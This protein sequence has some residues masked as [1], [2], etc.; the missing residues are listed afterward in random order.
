[1]KRTLALVI[2]ATAA[3]AQD[4]PLSAIDWLSEP[5]P[6]TIVSRL[7]PLPQVSA[8][9][10]P[11]GVRAP[12]AGEPAVSGPINVPQVTSS[13][14]M[15]DGLGTFGLLE[16]APGEVDLWR[17]ADT[18]A[19]MRD[20][21]ALPLAPLP[22]VEKMLER[23]LLLSVNGPSGRDFTWARLKR[24]R[25][26]GH[27][28]QIVAMLESSYPM[29]PETTGIYLDAAL[30]TGREAHACMV[31]DRA[32]QMRTLSWPAQ[33]YCRAVTGDW[34][35]AVTLLTA[36]DG[37][38]AMDADHADLLGYFLDPDLFEHEATPNVPM[39]PLAYRIYDS[40]GQYRTA[41]GPDYDN[42]R[43]S[44]HYGWKTRAEAA[45]RLARMGAIDPADL[46]DIMHAGRPSASGS[47]WERVTAV[48]DVERA[49]GDDEALVEAL[50]NFNQVFGNDPLI[51]SYAAQW[52][53]QLPDIPEAW[54]LRLLAGK[55]M[56]GDRLV[57]RISRDELIE[58]KTLTPYENAVAT[59]FFVEPDALPKPTGSLGAYLLHAARLIEEG[60]TGSPSALRDG[61][62]MLRAADPE[63]ARQVA[64][65]YLLLDQR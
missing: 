5:V 10:V 61:L 62:V 9:D 40:I 4:A 38:G 52:G 31:L 65:E 60:R 17:G 32:D 6:E 1:M 26:T 50:Q 49:L 37:L 55:Q 47:V 39:S 35:G 53:D 7:P 12:L 2:W 11:P 36:A 25:E 20:L 23:L 64:V 21:D 56:P 43:L 34:L 54:R 42:H 28:P 14:L 33:S 27:V 46:L 58:R 24:L 8:R 18:N 30:L 44:P 13:A 63:R 29:H 57:E 48:Q 22:A 51:A 59:A 15:I 45:E 19:V 3:G 41:T 16:P